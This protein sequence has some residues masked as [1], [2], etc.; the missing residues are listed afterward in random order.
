MTWLYMNTS[1][2][3]VASGLIP[4][5]MINSFAI[6][7]AIKVGPGLSISLCL[8]VIIIFLFKGFSKNLEKREA[9]HKAI[10]LK[11]TF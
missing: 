4:H 11:N 2:N 8:V 10:N 7:G 5:Y 3:W 1:G 6:N 9:F